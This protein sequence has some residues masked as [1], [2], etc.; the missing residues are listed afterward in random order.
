[1]VLDRKAVRQC[2]KSPEVTRA[3]VTV[4]TSFHVCNILKNPLD[5]VADPERNRKILV[6]SGS[7]GF[8]FGARVILEKK[9]GKQQHQILKRFL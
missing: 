6:G 7:K 1:M 8:R 4:P 9:L 3:S 5:R 2:R